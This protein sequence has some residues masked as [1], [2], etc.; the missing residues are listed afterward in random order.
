MHPSTCSPFCAITHCVCGR[1]AAHGSKTCGYCSPLARER[2]RRAELDAR[3]A[4][5]DALR[6]SL[7]PLPQVET[8]YWPSGEIRSVTTTARGLR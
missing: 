4:V 8:T 5:R 6:A 7:P 1:D 2:I 3:R